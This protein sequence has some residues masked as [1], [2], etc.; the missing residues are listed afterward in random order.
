M[1]QTRRAFWAKPQ[2]PR[3][4]RGFAYFLLLLKRYGKFWTQLEELSLES[5]VNGR[6]LH[7]EALRGRLYSGGLTVLSCARYNAGMTAEQ[8]NHMRRAR[9]LRGCAAAFFSVFVG[10]VFHTGAGG[11]ASI[12]ACLFAFLV[13][14]WLG[15]VL[16]AL[17]LRIVSVVAVVAAGQ[18]LLHVFMTFASAASPAPR[19]SGSLLETSVHALCMGLVS[20]GAGTAAPSAVSHADYS[21]PLMLAAHA[22]AV[23]LTA[24]Y[25]LFGERALEAVLTEIVGPVVFVFLIGA[26]P[27]VCRVQRPGVFRTRSVGAS[28]AFSAVSLRGP[29]AFV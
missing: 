7:D 29:P 16:S 20:P 18:W 1:G 11:A 21:G 19:G 8:K 3:L 5:C 10:L 12:A 28:Q 17:R 13:A 6:G 23:V 14:A 15:I 26:L 25:V 22:A 27:Q 4:T 2:T 9:M 24:G